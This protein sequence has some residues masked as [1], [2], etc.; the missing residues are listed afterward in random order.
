MLVLASVVGYKF[1]TL[2]KLWLMGG[3][4]SNPSNFI[5]YHAPWPFNIYYFSLISRCFITMAHVVVSSQVNHR[6]SII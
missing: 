4:A 1:I 2:F 5:L 6:T 3:I